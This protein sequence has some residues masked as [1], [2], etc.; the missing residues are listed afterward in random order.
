MFSNQADQPVV[1]FAHG[2]MLVHDRR[3]DETQALRGHHVVRLDGFKIMTFRD[4]SNPV[5]NR[6]ASAILHL[7]LAGRSTEQ[8][9]NPAR[10]HYL[11]F[12]LLYRR[13]F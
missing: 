9:D 11:T 4:I 3:F 10:E 13:G 8:I 7:T 1:P 6:D 2:E 12:V 5:M